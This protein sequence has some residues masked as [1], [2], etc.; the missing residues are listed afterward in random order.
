MLEG[1]NDSRLDADRS[2]KVMLEGSLAMLERQQRPDSTNAQ[3]H[4]QDNES[5]VLQVGRGPSETS[6]VQGQGDIETRRVNYCF[7][8][9]EA[10]WRLDG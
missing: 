4:N 9:G 6:V 2:K 3:T 8:G 5:E 10:F 7:A 1:G